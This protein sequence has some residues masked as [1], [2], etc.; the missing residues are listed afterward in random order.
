MAAAIFATV[1][2]FGMVC[3]CKYPHAVVYIIIHIFY[4]LLPGR[5]LLSPFFTIT[6]CFF[7]TGLASIIQIPW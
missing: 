6:H 7:N 2:S 5:H 3:G 1:A 4:Q